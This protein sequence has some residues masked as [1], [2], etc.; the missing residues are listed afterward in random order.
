[1][2]KVFTSEL[3]HIGEDLTA[4]SKQVHTAITTAS[5][6]LLHSDLTLA[7]QVIAADDAI[8]AAQ[9]ELDERCVMVL[10]RQQ[11]V[12]FD[13]R[14]VVT[15]LRMSGSLERMGDLARHIAQTARR[16][17]PAAAFPEEARELFL[18]F[19]A[20]SE[21]VAT[22]LIEV[23]T[24]H[25]LELALRLEADDD[26]LDELHRRALSMTQSPQWAG[27]AHHTVDVTLLARFYERFGDHAV[28]ISQRVQYLLTG[29]SD[30]PTAAD[31]AGL[32]TAP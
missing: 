17:A 20:A 7:Q 32:K 16:R 12:A 26:A 19:A 22:R 30:T 21:R 18:G 15:A 25:D 31:F 28:T 27:T 23:L 6:A 8:D 5:Q 4:M 10:A 14:L 9:T 29:S 3:S 13:L 24:T 11:P 2:R 1:M